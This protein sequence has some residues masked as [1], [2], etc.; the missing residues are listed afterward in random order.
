MCKADV[1]SRVSTYVGLALWAEAGNLREGVSRQ[2][3]NTFRG[4]NKGRG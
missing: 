1:P 2:K 3:E 4:S